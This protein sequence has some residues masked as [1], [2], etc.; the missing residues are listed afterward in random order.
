[1]SCKSER[2]GHGD[3][4]GHQHTEILTKLG[5]A[6]VGRLGAGSRAEILDSAVAAAPA[7]DESVLRVALA[8]QRVEAIG[9]GVEQA[10]DRQECRLAAPRRSRDGDVFALSDGKVDI[11]ERVG[12]D[13]VRIEHL[14]DAFHLDE[15]VAGS[16]P[17]RAS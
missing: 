13:L 9:R 10:K 14:L 3:L 16:T 2:L 7:V 8:R 12:L 17:A 5:S 11:G 6:G 4:R 15:R 1:M